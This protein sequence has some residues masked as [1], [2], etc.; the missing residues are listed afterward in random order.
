MPGAFSNVSRGKT[1][2]TNAQIT[3]FPFGFPGAFD[4]LAIPIECSEKQ[5]IGNTMYD[6]IN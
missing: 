2:A 5:D 4:S 3:V 1:D 6:M